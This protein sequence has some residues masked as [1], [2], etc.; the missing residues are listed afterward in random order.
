MI[1]F[2]REDKYRGYLRNMRKRSLSLAS[3]REFGGRWRL[4]ESKLCSRRKHNDWILTS[5]S[6]LS[7]WPMDNQWIPPGKHSASGHI[8]W[9]IEERA[10]DQL[11]Y[12]N[13]KKKTTTPIILKCLKKNKKK[14]F[15]NAVMSDS[16]GSQD[17]FSRASHSIH[18]DPAGVLLQPVE[19]LSDLVHKL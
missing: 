9:R 4:W 5:K 1:R 16:L 10:G 12:N 3:S 6:G 19:F 13:L 18:S 7:N 2:V 15:N 8:R 11:I 14:T 17:R